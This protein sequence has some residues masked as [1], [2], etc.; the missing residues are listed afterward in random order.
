MGA[1]IAAVEPVVFEQAQDLVAEMDGIREGVIEIL[2]DVSGGTID[3]AAAATFLELGFDSLLLSQ[4]ATQIQRKFSVKIAFRQSFGELSTI[5][6]LERFV[7][8]EATV[9]VERPAPA[10]VTA[11]TM[12]V[13]TSA[14]AT[15]MVP[16]A[17]TSLDETTQHRR[18]HARSGRGDVEPNPEAA[19]HA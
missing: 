13:T 10:A 2:Q 12:P 19:R 16:T 9:V 1:A 4:V 5:P 3:P 6:A 18:D 8:A 17:P 7:R 15:T 11:V 14:H